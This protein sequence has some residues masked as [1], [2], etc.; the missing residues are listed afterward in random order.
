MF[1]MFVVFRA[2]RTGTVPGTVVLLCISV[3]FDR[4]S[5]SACYVLGLYCLIEVQYRSFVS[6]RYCST[7]LHI[8]ILLYEYITCSSYCNRA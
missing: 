3:E 7:V 6:F 2:T 4:T 1:L 5:F 8:L